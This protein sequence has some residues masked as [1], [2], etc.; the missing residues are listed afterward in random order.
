[1]RWQTIVGGLLALLTN[2]LVSLIISRHSDALCRLL[3]WTG[4]EPLLPPCG[5][6]CLLCSFRP[7]VAAAATVAADCSL[8]WPRFFFFFLL[9]PWVARPEPPV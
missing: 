2:V 8:S 3:G 6:G 1:M 7:P 5:R 9:P 4:H